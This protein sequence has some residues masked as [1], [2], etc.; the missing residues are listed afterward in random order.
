[1][2]TFV[3]VLRCKDNIIQMT[4]ASFFVTFFKK[5]SFFFLTGFKKLKKGYFSV[6][7]GFFNQILSKTMSLFSIT[8]LVPIIWSDFICNKRLNVGKMLETIDGNKI[9]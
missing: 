4:C 1:M 8:T 2:K 3:F 6:K 7:K 5:N 9:G